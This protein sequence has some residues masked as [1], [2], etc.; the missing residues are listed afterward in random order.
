MFDSNLCIVH[1][2]MI[3]N[4]N[5]NIK[6]YHLNYNRF[7]NHIHILLKPNK[8]INTLCVY[9]F[10]CLHVSLIVT[11]ITTKTKSDLSIK[12]KNAAFVFV[13]SDLCFRF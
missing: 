4:K 6:T 5:K 12:Q 7:K 2:F 8:T 3:Y 9:C 1:S 10:V 11:T 13:K